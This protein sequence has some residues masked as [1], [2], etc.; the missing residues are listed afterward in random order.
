MTYLERLKKSKTPYLGTVLAAKSHFDSFGSSDLARFQK[1]RRPFDSK[2]SS[3]ISRFQKIT[4]PGIPAFCQTGC[5]W[6]ETLTLPGEGQTPGCANALSWP[7]EWRRLD[8]LTACPA[9]SA[10]RRIP[11][12]PPLPVWCQPDCQDRTQTTLADGRLIRVC[13]HHGWRGSGIID[14]MNGCPRG[15]GDKK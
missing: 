11:V 9:R 6:L 5:P 8:R 14:K 10:T 2:D 7:G 1:K 13:W 3:D 4:V 15:K 12:P